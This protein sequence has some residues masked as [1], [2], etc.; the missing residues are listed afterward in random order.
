LAA[1]VIPPQ[2]NS[3]ST[4]AIFQD[5]AKRMGFEES[6]FSLTEDQC[7]DRLLTDPSPYL[8]G[9]DKDT[10]RSGHAVHLDIPDNPYAETFKTPSGK[11]EFFS[12]A[13][14]EKGL[15][16]LPDGRPIRDPEGGT[17]F[18]LEFI[19]PPH[20]LFLN[21][22]FNEIAALREA[23]GPPAVLIHPETAAARKIG[24]GA[25][26][27]VYNDRGDCYLTARVTKDTQPGL[28]VAEGLRWP[29]FHPEGK[30]ANQLTSQRLTD[31]GQ[32]CAFHCNRVE[33]KPC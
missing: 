7:I 28:L 31:A 30:G 10:V 18:P 27:R 5:L 20:R 14:A 16:P 26:V 22:A 17:R 29:G 32:T 3:R 6:V 8:V 21:S 12:R 4:L 11:V 13:W 19:T 33:V 9:V 2:G 25:P 24:N 1:P 15:D 23:A